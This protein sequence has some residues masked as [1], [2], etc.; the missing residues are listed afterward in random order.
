MKERLVRTLTQTLTNTHTQLHTLTHIHMFI[1]IHTHTHTHRRRRVMISEWTK[2]SKGN[3]M[4]KFIMLILLKSCRNSDV[5][6]HHITSCNTLRR[7]STVVGDRMRNE[8]PNKNG[9]SQGR[10]LGRPT[11]EA[12]CL[13]RNKPNA[14]DN[15]GPRLWGLSQGTYL[16]GLLLGEWLALSRC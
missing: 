15:W 12:E 4:N 3:H 7:S 2:L 9:R 11:V 10:T 1:D 14:S 6:K 8:V 13:M 16:P 5:D